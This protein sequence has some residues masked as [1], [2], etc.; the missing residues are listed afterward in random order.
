[1]DARLALQKVRPENLVGAV[2]LVPVVAHRLLERRDE[3]PEF[4]S[5]R[6]HEVHH[7]ALR[8]YVQ[9]LPG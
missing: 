6:V 9:G 3:S 5:A 2:E 4:V 8:L 1:V 7:A